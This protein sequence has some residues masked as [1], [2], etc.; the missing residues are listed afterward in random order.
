MSVVT[1]LYYAS[2]LALCIKEYLCNLYPQMLIEC[3][4]SYKSYEI[5]FQRSGIHLVCHW[6]NLL[7]AES[8]SFRLFSRRTSSAILLTQIEHCKI[9]LYLDYLN[10]V[11]QYSEREFEPMSL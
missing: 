1:E 3:Y 4:K 9:D 5:S 6:S 10:I 7:I 11:I 8:N 2:N